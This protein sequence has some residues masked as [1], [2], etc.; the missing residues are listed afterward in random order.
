[1]YKIIFCDLDDTLL[2]SDKSISLKNKEWIKKARAK[3]VKFVVCTGRVLSAVANI[4]EELELKDQEG[5][6]L[7]SLNGG[8]IYENNGKLLYADFLPK[9]VAETVFQK[10]VDLDICLRIYTK[11]NFYGYNLDKDTKLKE[12]YQNVQTALK[13]FFTPRLD[14]LNGEDLVKIVF[15]DDDRAKLKKIENELKDLEVELTYSSQRSLEINH[16]GV[17]KGSG[18]LWLSDYLGFSKEEVIAIGDNFNDVSM[19]KTAG[20]GVCVKNG[21]KEVKKIAKYISEKTN[22]EAAVAEVIEKFI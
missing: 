7:I 15:I 8:A 19:L 16:K 9:T 3:G 21:D 20:L 18:L 11:D 2:N 12:T 1:M 6:F 5:E 17:N 22:D 13:E 4:L 14:F 10:G